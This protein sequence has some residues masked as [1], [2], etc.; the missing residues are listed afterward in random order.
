MKPNT[1]VLKVP[2][3]KHDTFDN[4]AFAGWET[5]GAQGL[6]GNGP[7]CQMNEIMW[8]YRH[9]ETK[10]RDTYILSSNLLK[11]QRFLF[12]C[13]YCKGIIA[14]WRHQM[15]KFSA[16]LAICAGNSPVTGEF[17]AQKP[18][19]RSF[20][21]FLDLRLNKRLSKQSWG[22]WFET[23]QRPLWRHSNGVSSVQSGAI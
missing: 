19:T 2:K 18:V 20:D 4:R 21:V 22:W 3:F 5:Y 14:W 9:L 17:L 23:L 11:G 12:R 15:E 1:C 10:L 13:N 8:W 16:L 7:A 6:W